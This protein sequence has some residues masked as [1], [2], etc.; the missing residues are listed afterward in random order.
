MSAQVLET[1]VP[2]EQRVAALT[3]LSR[4][5][6]AMGH[7]DK[8]GAALQSA[9]LIAERECPQAAVDAA[10]PACRRRH[11]DGR[12]RRRAALGGPRPG[13]RPGGKASRSWRRPAAKWG[14]HGLLLWRPRR[15]HRRRVRG[16]APARCRAR[17]EVAADIRAG[18]SRCARAVRMRRR[19]GGALR[20]GGDGV[21][22]RDRRGRAGRRSDPAAALRVPYG[23]M[24]LRT[25]LADSLAVADRL[26]AVADLVPLAEPFARTMKAL[27]LPG[28]WARS[29]RARPRVNGHGRPP[30]P[31]ASG[32]A[33]LAGPRARPPPICATGGS[34]RPRTR[35]PRWRTRYRALGIGE[36]C[37]VPFAR[38]AVV[39]HVRA[40]R[41]GRRGASHRLAGRVRRP[42][43]VPVAGGRRSRRTGPA[44]PP[45]RRPRRG[46]PWRTGRPSSTSTASRFPWSRPELMIEHGAMLRRDG[47]ALEARESLKRAGELA[48]SV[49]AVWLARRAGEELAA[50]GGRRRSPAGGAGA[51]TAGAGHHQAGGHRRIG[52]GHRHPPGGVGSHRTDPSRACV[53]QA[54][55]PLEA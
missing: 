41:S 37:I 55:D 49:G 13:A 23:L 31:S 25:R 35:M 20:R 33:C 19:A 40:G 38:H 7:I 9:V 27:R 54:R 6:F 21:P 34:R 28:A 16:P 52:Q 12:A 1:D 18:G 32:S 3:M 29:S 45:A 15:P 44:R 43:T 17:A 47:R 26:L 42:P 14:A 5:H 2:P 53:R 22:R 10:L 39:A 8:A 11:D 36:P 50:A 51:H 30:A 46:R 24:L 4:A 48:E